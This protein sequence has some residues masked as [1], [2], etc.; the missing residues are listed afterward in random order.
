[1]YESFFELSRRPFL[2]GPHAE[3]YVP[4]QAAEESR[5][6]L[7][8]CLRRAEGPALL[9]GPAGCGKTLILHM[10][11]CEL[12]EEFRVALLSSTRLCTRRALLQA[13]LFELGL[14]YRELDEGELRLSLIEYLGNPERSGA[15]LVLLVDEAHHLPI[16]LL[17]EVRMITNLVAEGQSRVRL[18]LAGNTQLE[19]RFASPKLESFNQRIAARCYLEPLAREETLYYVRSQLGHAAGDADRIFSSEA[20]ETIYRATDGIPRLINQVCDHA[21]M[22][23]HLGE[24]QKL[25]ATGIEEA[26]SDLQQLPGP[27]RSG[28][29][30]VGG[31]A[32][33]VEFG[34]LDD[35]PPTPETRLDEMERQIAQLAAEDDRDTELETEFRPVAAPEVELIFHG[36]H[37][38]FGEDFA[39][40]EVISDRYATLDAE[41]EAGETESIDAAAEYTAEEPVYVGSESSGQGVIAFEQYDLHPPEAVEPLANEPAVPLSTPA[42]EGEHPAVAFTNAAELDD[43]V[44][45]DD[46]DLIVVENPPEDEVPA[47]RSNPQRTRSPQRYRQLF[48]QLRQS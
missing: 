23:S 28:S 35:D 20:L 34:S 24:H 8:R 21:L 47:P 41:A 29:E 31:E 5:Q 22:M 16:R 30:P 33:I 3:L 2:A 19:E 27:W 43:A 46:R 9:M 4:T 11:A 17:D 13:I 1:M 12:K 45:E 6:T 44:D 26:W 10:I 18:A 7:L 36:P 37:D 14:P 48:S 39:E 42:A 25:D 40:E 32:G 15:G 38:P